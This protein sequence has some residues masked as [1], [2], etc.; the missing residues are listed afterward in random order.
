LPKDEWSTAVGEVSHGVI[1]VRGY[2]ITEV[3]QRLSFADAVFLTIRGDL[4]D[5]AQRRL[6]DAAL[7][8][9]LEHGF[10]APTTVAA[11]VVASA[12]PQ[13]VIP[14]LAAGILT[15]GAVTVSPQ[16]SAELI[17][18]MQAQMKSGVN[19]EDAAGEIAAGLVSSG[20]RMP[21]LGHPLHPEGD[22]RAEALQE[23][24]R[25]V[26]LW[27]GLSMSYLAIRDAY[28]EMTQRNLPVN[29]DGMLGCVLAELG[30]T[31]IEMPGIAAISFM[32]GIVAHCA[33]EL[34]APPTLRIAS[35]PYTGPA[36]RHLV[37]GDGLSPSA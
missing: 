30:F 6:M 23:V 9:I 7:C 8:A 22:P 20:A 18:Q 19:E 21:G 33:E 4:P 26:G 31:P 15:I 25:Q 1:N 32:P 13:T 3:I 16:H 28:L 14:G 24:A 11:R 17:D 5:A 35:G 29:V 34:S 10:Y 27:T 2:P 36:V 37:D 12:A